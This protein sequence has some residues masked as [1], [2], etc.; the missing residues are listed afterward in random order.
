MSS[1]CDFGASAEEAVEDAVTSQ[2]TGAVS[3]AN[4]VP[5]FDSEV[6]GKMTLTHNTLKEL[7][8]KETKTDGVCTMMAKVAL[9]ALTDSLVNWINSGFEGGP[10]FVTDFEGFM[11][12]T[13]DQIAGTFIKDQLGLGFLCEPF[14]VNIQL[15]LALKYTAKYAREA[16]CTL[17]EVGRNIENAINNASIGVNASLTW[18]EWYDMTQKPQNN[19]YGAEMMA[20]SELAFQIQTKTGTK[21]AVLDWG[22]GFK[23]LQGPDGKIRTPGK[24]ISDSL[25]GSMKTNFDEL[26]MADEVDKVVAALARYLVTS[27]IQKGVSGSSGSDSNSEMEKVRANLTTFSCSG[28]KPTSATACLNDTT[29]L[30]VETTWINVTRRTSCTETRKCEYFIPATASSTA[31]STASLDRESFIEDIVASS[32]SR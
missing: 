9:G 24:T 17:T 7:V 12:N 26:G 13:A 11:T 32:T 18:D 3:G 8:K 31:S 6:Y 4:K 2:A 28:I 10:A 22:N 25:S 30:T 23:S 19:R 14:R 29:G 21:K 27:I 15:S 20:E 16:R 5:V 1:I